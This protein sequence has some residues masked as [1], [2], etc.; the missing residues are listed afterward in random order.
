MIN[1]RIPLVVAC[2]AI[3]AAIA[4]TCIGDLDNALIA[5]MVA[6]GALAVATLSA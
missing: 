3:M 1:K 4:L 5:I 2:T 6:A